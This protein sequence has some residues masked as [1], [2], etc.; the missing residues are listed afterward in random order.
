MTA[1]QPDSEPSLGHHTAH[2]EHHE[3]HEQTQATPSSKAHD[4]TP[5]QHGRGNGSPNTSDGYLHGFKFV[6]VLIALF[7][8]IFCMAL[9]STC[10]PIHLRSCLP[11]TQDNTIIA[12]AIP[13]ITDQFHSINDVGWY[14]SAYL[15]TTCAFQL[16]YGKLY[17]FISIKWTYFFALTVFEIGSLICGVAPNSATLIVGRAVAGVGAAGL[18]SG[19]IVIISRVA[20]PANRPMWTAL[21]G[22]MFGIASVV[23]PL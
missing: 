5:D 19:C 4:A 3:Y 15:L 20:P 6:L 10:T 11:S 23:G 13:R 9:V 12:T 2:D 8:A 21:V 18:F 14:G 7:L 22:G 1:L 17:G 16:T